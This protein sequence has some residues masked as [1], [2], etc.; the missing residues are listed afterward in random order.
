MRLFLSLVTTAL[1]VLESEVSSNP[2]DLPDHRNFEF[3]TVNCDDILE[4]NRELKAEIKWLNNIIT[5]NI[6]ELGSLISRNGDDITSLEGRVVVNEFG[7]DTEIPN[8][9]NEVNERIDLF[10]S[11]TDDDIDSLFTSLAPVGTIVGINHQGSLPSGWQLCDGSLILTGILA[12]QTTPNLNSEGYFLRGG[13]SPG[14]FQEDQIH[15]H[16]HNTDLHDPG[17][18]HTDAGRD[19]IYHDLYARSEK[20]DDANDRTMGS[21]SMNE[22]APKSDMGHAQISNEKTGISVTLSG[23][24][25]AKTGGETRPKNMAV[26]WI[27]RIE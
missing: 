24:T 5:Y 3:K 2:V 20:G 13:V 15:E 27:I 19:H 8:T 10:E 26:T 6:S 1:T 17:H 25:G 14:T 12:G 18:K 16:S 11:E 22:R 23:T 9:F 21:D 4:E 7:I